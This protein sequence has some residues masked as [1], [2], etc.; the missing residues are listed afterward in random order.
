MSITVRD[1]AHELAVSVHLVQTLVDELDAERENYPTVDPDTGEMSDLSADIIR[2]EIQI[3]GRI[4]TIYL[5]AGQ[6]SQRLGLA[7]DTVAKWRTRYP[8]TPEPD[9][10]IGTTYGWLP[11]SI[12]QWR[13]WMHDRPGQG[14]G[15]GP[16]PY[17]ITVSGRYRL[18]DGT[19]VHCPNCGTETGLTFMGFKTGDNSPRVTCPTCATEWIEESTYQNVFWRDAIRSSPS[20]IDT[21]LDETQAAT[22]STADNQKGNTM[23][24]NPPTQPLVFRQDTFRKEARDIYEAAELLDHTNEETEAAINA[25]KRRF[26]LDFDRND[27]AIEQDANGQW[28]NQT[29]TRVPESRLYPYQVIA[30]RNA[31]SQ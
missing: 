22:T 5:S 27:N 17:R 10:R 7:K 16:K 31:D 6:L 20:W 4:T 3:T 8:D 26:V 30:A 28:I 24:S 2:R 12:S 11:E 23:P 18:T 13:E 15:G 14:S 9:A 19:V 21:E 29:G 1:L 25:L